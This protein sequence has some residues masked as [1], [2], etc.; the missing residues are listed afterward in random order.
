M[1]LKPEIS[2]RLFI[3]K[4]RS[5]TACTSRPH[6]GADAEAQNSGIRNDAGILKRVRNG[7]DKGNCCAAARL[8]VKA[9][10]LK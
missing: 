3:F 7:Y 2:W 6:H 10:N 9:P 8:Y 4:P 5:S 1:A